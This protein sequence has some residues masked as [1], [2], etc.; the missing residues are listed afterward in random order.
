MIFFEIFPWNSNFETGIEIINTQHKELVRI[1]NLLAASL[2]NHSNDIA[3]NSIFDELAEYVEYHFKTEEALW[4][5]YFQDDAWYLEHAKSHISFVD[6]VILLKNNENNKPLDEVI[7]NII[8][9]LSH[10]LAYHILDS[11][12]RMSL[13]VHAINAGLSLE[14]AKQEANDKMS[15]S[16]TFLLNTVLSMYDNLSNRTL[17]LIREKSLRIQAEEAFNRSEERWKFILDGGAENVWDWDIETNKFHKSNEGIHMFDIIGQDVEDAK[18]CSRI[19]PADVKNVK[20][21][22]DAHLNG[23]TEFYSNK[24]RIIRKSGA[25]R[26]VLSRG[27]VV[28]RDASGKAL[29]MIGTHSDITERELATLIYKNSSEAIFI[30]NAEKEIISINPSFTKITG[31]EE[32]DVIGKNPKFLSSGIQDNN[33]YKEMWDRLNSTGRYSCEVYNKRKDSTIFLEAT[34][35]NVVTDANGHVDHYFALFND[36]TELNK[37]KKEQEKQKELS[38]QQSRMAQM[39][40]MISMIAHQWRQP[41][42][43]IS[44]TSIDLT[45]QIEMELFDLE[46]KQSR[47]ACQ[48]YFTN[49]LKEIDGFVQNLTT[50]IDDFRNFYKPNK[51]SD[52]VLLQ[53]PIRKALG[54][55]RGTLLSDGIE[56]VEKCT[57]KNSVNLYSNEIVQVILNILKNGHD[58]FREKAIKNPKITL[59]CEDREDKVVLEICDNGGGIAEDVLPSIFDPYFS[60]KTEKNGTGLG[61]YMSKTIIE[62]HHKGSLVATNRD[63]GACFTIVFDKEMKEEI[64]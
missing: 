36:I 56:I 14:D 40:E 64:K 43:A 29:R 35:V 60:T 51:E 53:E 50:T 46:D 24:H 34:E 7:Q 52:F 20:D 12:K 47:E 48:V 63:G 30:C 25:W 44:A 62:E 54:I 1:I 28:N 22:L 9:F 42:G 21:D 19:H 55:I 59:T 58:N 4:L 2:A 15:D 3:L 39:G 41:L 57:S 18:E 38:I 5:K 32:K 8:S 45:M 26:W 33:F 49:R 37:S 16:M 31:Y 13:A 23:K 10:W 27:K 6:K 11:D 17:E 61:L